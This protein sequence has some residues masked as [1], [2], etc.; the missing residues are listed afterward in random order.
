MAGCA[1][2]LAAHLLLSIGI[3]VCTASLLAL[4]LRKIRQ[5]KVI[6]EVLGGIL[7]GACA[8]DFTLLLGSFTCIYSGPTAFGEF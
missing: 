4:V 6:A 3:I 2:I 5:P 8:F 7:L 1:D